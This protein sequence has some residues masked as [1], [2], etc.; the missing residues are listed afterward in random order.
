MMRQGAEVGV[1]GYFVVF[2]FGEQ[3]FGGRVAVAVE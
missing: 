1:E 2:S 3:G